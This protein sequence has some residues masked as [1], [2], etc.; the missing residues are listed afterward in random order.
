MRGGKITIR[1]GFD[2]LGKFLVIGWND[3]VRDWLWKILKTKANVTIMHHECPQ[4]LP[5][6]VNWQF[7]WARHEESLRRAIRGCNRVYLPRAQT[8]NSEMM[9]NLGY[10]MQSNGIK[11][12]RF[13]DA[14]HAGDLP[15]TTLGK[16]DESGAASFADGD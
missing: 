4:D 2:R 12:L 14:S 8:L 5:C 11:E 7:G 16:K 15:K 3:D 1:P 10:L 13:I 9:V 6:G